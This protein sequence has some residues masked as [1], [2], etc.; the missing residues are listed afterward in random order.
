MDEIYWFGVRFGEMS[1]IDELSWIKEISWFSE[2]PW[3]GELPW[4]KWNLEKDG[5][6]SV[7]GE[8]NLNKFNIQNAHAELLVDPVYHR[9][10][11][12]LRL[13]GYM[14]GWR[15]KY[16]H[17]HNLIQDDNCRICQL[18]E[19]R[20]FP[21]NETEKAEQCFFQW[22]SERV[23]RALKSG[24]MKRFVVQ[25]GVVYDEGRL[26]PEF[27]F[28]TNDLD[29][30][31]YL[32]KHQIVGRILVVL[33]DSPVL[34]AYP[35]YVHTKMLIQPGILESLH[36]QSP[37]ICQ[38]HNLERYSGVEEFYSLVSGEE[39][40]VVRGFIDLTPLAILAGYKF[41][42]RNMTAMGVQVLETLLN[43]NVSTD[44]LDGSRFWNP[45][46]VMHQEISCLD[47]CLIMF[48]LV[49]CCKMCFQTLMFCAGS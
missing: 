21:R 9:S 19:H 7:V 32:D 39:V 26:S 20:W 29:W 6:S 15:T 38:S 31:G 14:Q 41:Q 45:S 1:G 47:S 3:L 17:N 49:S 42:S 13:T 27:H 16:C 33:P 23:K 37:C 28:K 5:L 43:K 44:V 30:V 34:Y 8:L 10:M 40:R 18:G 48:C 46:D 2:M 36:P 25:N 4:Y 12:A 22:E 24:E 11:K 35:M